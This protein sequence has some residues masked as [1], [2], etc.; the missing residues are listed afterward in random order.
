MEIAAK[1]RIA[2]IDTETDLN[3]RNL[4]KQFDYANSLS[5][6]FIVIIGERE[7]KS[8]TVTFRDMKSGK[9]ENVTVEKAVE[10]VR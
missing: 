2:G 7:A 10:K 3:N 5:I 8:N 6:P 4:R 9:E 1:F